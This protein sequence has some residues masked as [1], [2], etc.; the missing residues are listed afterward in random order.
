MAVVKKILFTAF[1]FLAALRWANEEK[2]QVAHEYYPGS[3]LKEQISAQF[4][5]ARVDTVK[6][7]FSCKPWN[8]DIEYHIMPLQNDTAQTK[9]GIYCP[10]K[11]VI[12]AK[13]KSGTIYDSLDVATI[14]K[15]IPDLNN[16]KS[17]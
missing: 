17:E 8:G 10:Q 2:L 4:I 15:T 1:L 14:R 11:V 3:T 9:S 12:K 16:H 7:T 5:S 13:W 6:I